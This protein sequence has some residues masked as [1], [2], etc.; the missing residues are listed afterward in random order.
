MKVVQRPQRA[1]LA[2]K[3]PTAT[4]IA[5]HSSSQ[6]TILHNQTKQKSNIVLAQ[7]PT[8]HPLYSPRTAVAAAVLHCPRCRRRRRRRR[9]QPCCRRSPDAAIVGTV[10]AALQQ[11]QKSSHAPA[12]AFHDSE[13]R[14]RSSP[15]TIVVA[16]LSV[17]VAS[18]A[19]APAW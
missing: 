5:N 19:A 12:P 13:S 7:L 14:Y 17:S 6:I 10:V 3:M 1:G 18:E 4:L 8:L 9:W 16:A 2:Q 11:Q 15:V